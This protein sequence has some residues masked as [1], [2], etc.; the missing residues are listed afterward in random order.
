M[1]SIGF[2]LGMTMA[3]RQAIASRCSAVGLAE[4]ETGFLFTPLFSAFS[5]DCGTEGLAEAGFV[6]GPL[7]AFLG[8]RWLSAFPGQAV[9]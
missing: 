1:T 5:S 4:G 8:Q 7:P 2:S 9:A 3:L 6:P